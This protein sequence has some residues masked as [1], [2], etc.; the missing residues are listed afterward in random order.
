VAVHPSTTHP[1]RPAR[2]WVKERI[3]RSKLGQLLRPV[4]SSLSATLAETRVI[5]LASPPKLVLKLTPPGPQ[6]S[7]NVGER[8]SRQSHRFAVQVFNEG[9]GQRQLAY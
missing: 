4:A 3:T 1:R 2:E 6:Q 5:A 7:G 9:N 8:G